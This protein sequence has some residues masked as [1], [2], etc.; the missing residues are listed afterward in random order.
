MWE[1]PIVKEVR[2]VRE[3]YAARF[4]YDLLAICR[5]LKQQEQNSGRRFVSYAPR[6][7]GRTKKPTARRGH[8]VQQAVEPPSTLAI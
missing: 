5:D 1:D 6:R 4:D 7:V 3:A 2:Q 8:V